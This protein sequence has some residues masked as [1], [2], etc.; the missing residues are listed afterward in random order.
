MKLDN[1]TEI[2]IV[3]A[4]QFKQGKILDEFDGVKHL[5]GYHEPSGLT[6]NIKNDNTKLPIQMSMEWVFNHVI[7]KK[8]IKLNGNKVQLSN[9]MIRNKKIVERYVFAIDKSDGIGYF[10]K[11]SNDF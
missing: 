8:L 9:A 3:E 11:L 5:K 4:K 6:L 10:I 1:P 2:L 7:N